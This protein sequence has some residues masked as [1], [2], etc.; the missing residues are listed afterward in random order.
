[1]GKR[2]GLDDL[3]EIIKELVRAENGAIVFTSS[4]GRQDS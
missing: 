4:T 3:S 2:K 1:M